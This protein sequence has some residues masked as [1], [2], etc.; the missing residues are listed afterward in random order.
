MVPLN[1]SS[2][3]IINYYLLQYLIP[4]DSESEVSIPKSLILHPQYAKEALLAPELNM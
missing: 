1:S 4:Y 3:M 2:G